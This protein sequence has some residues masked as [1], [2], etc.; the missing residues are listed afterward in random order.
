MYLKELKKS[1]QTKEGKSPRPLPKTEDTLL[2]PKT[3]ATM[4]RVTSRDNF[5]KFQWPWIL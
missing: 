5:I 2:S 3:I 1:V 4:K